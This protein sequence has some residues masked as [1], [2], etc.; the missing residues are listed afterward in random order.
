MQPYD[1]MHLATSYL[2]LQRM[3]YVLY[4]RSLHL[5]YSLLTDNIIPMKSIMTL[6]VSTYSQTMITHIENMWWRSPYRLVSSKELFVAD[7]PLVINCAGKT[8]FIRRNLY[9][10]YETVGFVPGSIFFLTFCTTQDENQ[11]SE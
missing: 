10:T 8:H 9:K 11:F 5:T 4:I 2:G 6:L 3:Y 1:V 7:A